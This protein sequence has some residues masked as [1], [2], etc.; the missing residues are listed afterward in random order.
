[1]IVN[2]SG[3]PKPNLIEIEKTFN[4]RSK[5]TTMNYIRIEGDINN[6]N[7]VFAIDE[8]L[9]ESARNILNNQWELNAYCPAIVIPDIQSL[10]LIVEVLVDDAAID[11][12]L[13]LLEDNSDGTAIV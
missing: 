7:K 2:K 11:Q 9:P 5:N 1:M 6:I 3:R 8:V 4:Y 13:A 12:H 10:G